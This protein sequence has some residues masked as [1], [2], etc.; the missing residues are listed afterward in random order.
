MAFIAK[1]LMDDSALKTI[2]DNLDS[3]RSSLD[4]WLSFWTLLAV[5]GVVLEV[6]FV[7]CEYRKE[8]HEFRQGINNFGLGIAHPPEKPSLLLF[9]LGMLGAGLVAAG[10]S[11]ELYISVQAGKVE[12]EIR[13]V[14]EQRV[15]LLSREAGDAK[16][17]AK[18]AASASASAKA[19]AE[20]AGVAAGKAQQKVVALAK[21]ADDAQKKLSRLQF[22]VLPRSERLMEKAHLFVTAMEPFA[23]QKVE[24]KTDLASIHDPNDVQETRLFVST[25]GFLLGQVSN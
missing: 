6:V 23:G 1:F 14:N 9:V 13:K 18:G 12:T 19:S 21:Q 3:Y 22:L 10:V 24:I 16:D 25:I 20:A 15:S 17:S 2:L 8:L 4:G 11:G 7:I 5:I